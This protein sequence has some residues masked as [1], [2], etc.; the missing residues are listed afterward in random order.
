MGRALVFSRVETS[1]IPI[2]LVSPTTVSVSASKVTVGQVL[3]KVVS[4]WS[5][6]D[7]TGMV[8]SGT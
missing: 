2:I 3:P 1:R 7:D 4:G 5:V 8:G 6:Y